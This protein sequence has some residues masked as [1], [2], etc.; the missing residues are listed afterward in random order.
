MTLKTAQLLT[1]NATALLEGGYGSGLWLG[2][3]AA[4]IPTFEQ[5]KLI[6]TSHIK[7]KVIY[8]ACSV[9]GTQLIQFLTPA[10]AGAVFPLN[11]A[12]YNLFILK[13]MKSLV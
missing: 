4:A 7:L 10:I 1:S 8:Q 5:K 9:Y 11:Q 3:S 2:L 13:I 6:K 12:T